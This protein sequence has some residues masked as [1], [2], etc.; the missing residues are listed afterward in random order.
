MKDVYVTEKIRT[1][2]SSTPVTLSVLEG[3]QL[4][5]P[6]ISIQV[7]RVLSCVWRTLRIIALFTVCPKTA[8]DIP[9]EYCLSSSEQDVNQW[10][11]SQP[12]YSCRLDGVMVSSEVNQRR[13][14][15]RRRY[16]FLA[17]ENHDNTICYSSSSRSFTQV[18]VHSI[19]YKLI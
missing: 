1:M 11:Y 4:M 9:S 6:Q 5:S 13:L 16:I 18:F 12:K 7:L 17:P 3:V 14:R 15:L 19:D 8:T 10:R 2:K